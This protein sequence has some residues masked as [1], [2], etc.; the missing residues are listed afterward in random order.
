MSFLLPSGFLSV[1]L[2]S[3]LSAAHF[4]LNYPIPLG[5]DTENEGIAPCG[6]FKFDA[7]SNLSDFHVGGDAI[8][9]VTTHPQAN[10]LLRGSLDTSASGNWTD[11]FPVVAQYGLGAFCEPSIASPASWAGSSG[12]IQVIQDAVDG[13][14]YQVRKVRNF[15]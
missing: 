2:F 13:T 11:L 1:L 15:Y 9:M 4:T 8:S 14:L 12:I 10:I 6:G 7:S 3:T 5:S